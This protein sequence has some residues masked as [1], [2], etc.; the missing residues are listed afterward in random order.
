[1]TRQNP[2]P[3]TG[4]TT[5]A[6]RYVYTNMRERFSSF[7]ARRQ[8]LYYIISVV[9]YCN[10]CVPIFHTSNDICRFFPLPPLLYLLLLFLLLRINHR[11]SIVTYCRNAPW[12]ASACV[13]SGILA[14]KLTTHAHTTCCYIAYGNCIFTHPAERLQSFRL[15]WSG[16]IILCT[17]RLYGPHCTDTCIWYT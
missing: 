9:Y 5:Y 15:L 10:A 13:I 2:S 4:I 8:L 7:S 1:M 14:E 11:H 16:H 3:N 17:P 6:Y 12:T